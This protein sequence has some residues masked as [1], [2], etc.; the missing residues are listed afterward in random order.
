M[1]VL[2]ELFAGVST[3]SVLAVVATVAG[4]L[5]SLQV[6]R[7]KPRQGNERLATGFLVELA[8]VVTL[9]GWLCAKIAHV[10]FEAEGHVLDDGR[11]A[12]GVVDLL[13][14]DPWHWARLLEPGFV[15]Y[16]GVVGAVVCGWWFV[17]VSPE[18]ARL[19]AVCDIA[20]PGILVGVVVGR[21]GCLL[22]GCCYG[23]PSELPWAIHFPLAHAT[24]GV[25]VHP[26]QLYDAAV[27]VIGLALW[28]RFR[29]RLDDGVLFFALCA[30]YAVARFATELV[31]ADADRGSVGPLSTSQVISIIVLAVLLVSWVRRRAR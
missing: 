23:A 11:V 4:A 30:G 27:A 13:R 1:E 9:A 29:R 15:F 25:G 16:G 21:L 31:R 19:L 20:V 17:R 14:D 2:P 3:W 10:L 22:G 5:L 28:L 26:V 8:L 12:G 7:S 18:R 6:G 24:H